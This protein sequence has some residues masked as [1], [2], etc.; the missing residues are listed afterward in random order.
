M[1]SF[2]HLYRSS[3]NKKDGPKVRRKIKKAE[4]EKLKRDHMNDLFLELTKALGVT[5]I[6]STTLY[7][8][9]CLQV[10]ADLQRGQLLPLKKSNM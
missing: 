5:F 3:F 2:F 8:H 6:P 1:V 4:R 9:V 10:E 7:F